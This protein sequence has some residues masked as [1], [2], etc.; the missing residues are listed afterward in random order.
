MKQ[1][2]E[3]QELS[4]DINLLVQR[5][6]IE[7]M[8]RMPD[9]DAVL[10]YLL[11]C[12]SQ[13]VE[14][15]VITIAL[16]DSG[17]VRTF[18]SYYPKDLSYLRANDIF[19]VDKYVALKRA[20]TTRK[21]ILTADTHNHPDWIIDDQTE[22][23]RSH[24]AIPMFTQDEFFGFI[25][26]QGLT[27][28]QFSEQDVRR[29]QPLVAQTSLAV[30]LATM[31]RQQEQ[32]TS[33]LEALY[34]ATSVLLTTDNVRMLGSQIAEAV[35]KEFD[36]VDCGVILV[37]LYSPQLE[38][39]PRSGIEGLSTSEPLYLDGPGLVPAAIRSGITTYAPDVNQ[40]SRYVANVPEAKSE[41]VIPLRTHNN[42]IGV[43][44]L[45]SSQTHSF[46]PN[47]VRVL[48]AFAQ[49]AAVAIENARLYEEIRTFATDQEQLLA[50]RT[51]E[52]R[53]AKEQVETI[54]NYSSD[55]VAFTTPDGQ[56]IRT[57][58]AFE[59]IFGP[60]PPTKA[61][62]SIV[63][64]IDI[65]MQQSNDCAAALIRVANGKSPSE[66]LIATTINR[67][68]NPIYIDTTLAAV[69]NS[70]GHVSGIVF[71]IRDISDLKK[72]EDGL[73][74][75]L[76]HEMELNQMKSQFIAVVSH[77]FRTPLATILSAK[78]GLERYYD[79]LS[80]QQKARNFNQIDS[81]VIRMT[82]MLDD[83]L[84]LTQDETDQKQ[85]DRSYVDLSAVF[86]SAYEDLLANIGGDYDITFDIIGNPQFVRSNVNQMQHIFIN[87]V[88]N[89]IKYSGENKSVRVLLDYQ[90]H[91]FQLTV[92]DKGI[93]IPKADQ[94]HIFDPFIRGSNVG[95][96]RGTGLGLSI[97]ERAVRHH[98]GHID[99][100][101]IPDEGTTF[102][103]TIP[104]SNTVPDHNIGELL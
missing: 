5:M 82:E 87:L 41:L 56:I 25:F 104:Y 52:L 24:I 81:N 61:A 79:R 18:R 21:S 47:D 44:D 103:V 86:H 73:R 36:H 43:L 100:T 14:S 4:E 63:D 68:T 1:V 62:L 37:D 88:E 2:E 45:Q 28:N 101:S 76:A 102:V 20:Y 46:S 66:R 92:S 32:T 12:I 75:A 39:L 54:L 40:D 51:I 42:I 69:R 99:F 96:K 84:S 38:R 83:L 89:A 95:T 85:Q 34:N 94:S 33:E 71:T 29:I 16:L 67:D 55:G 11:S 3:P 8:Q 72:M 65:D 50:E 13:V 98:K 26:L 23:I 22:W 27:P 60:L 17:K 91:Q 10:D 93:G 7:V 77:E 78:D 15:D 6:P 74:D 97:V 70:R 9:I 80:D 31:Y 59:K 53:E 35:V 90:Q 48:E 58:T 49:R 57:N 30:H 19:N 64:L